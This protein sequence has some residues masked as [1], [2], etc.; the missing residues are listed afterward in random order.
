MEAWKGPQAYAQ[1]APGAH[2]GHSDIVVFSASR[3]S[4]ASKETQRNEVTN[5]AKGDLYVSSD[6]I[7]RSLLLHILI[8]VL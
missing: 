6:S 5:V 8:I 4:R 1:G 2:L 7:M 3:H